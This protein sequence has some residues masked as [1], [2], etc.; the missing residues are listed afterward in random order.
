MKYAYNQS[1]FMALQNSNQTIIIETSHQEEDDDVDFFSDSEIEREK[2]EEKTRE[3]PPKKPDFNIFDSGKAETT[4]PSKRPRVRRLLLNTQTQEDL[5][6]GP[7][8]E[9]KRRSSESH[10]LPV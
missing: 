9:V 8:R 6:E 3:S 5:V 2:T 7:E 4:K 1:D 10:T